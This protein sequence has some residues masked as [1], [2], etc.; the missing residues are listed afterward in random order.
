MVDRGSLEF[1]KSISNVHHNVRTQA[2]VNRTTILPED[3]EPTNYDVI[4]GRNKNAQVHVGNKR[5]RV[6]CKIYLQRYKNAKNS[7][8]KTLIF[9]EIVG[10]F[11]ENSQRGGF[12]SYDENR[13][14]WIEVGDT[15][16][17]EKVGQYLRQLVLKEDP[18][19]YEEVKARKNSIRREKRKKA[20]KPNRD[21]NSINASTKP[22]KGDDESLSDVTF[23]DVFS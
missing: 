18:K 15:I 13:N 21:T 10:V 6:T 4:C 2:P 11:R 12:V 22:I 19:K 17:R 16:A 23:E 8:E 20:L 5:F 1:N 14:R 9:M 7:F 3:F